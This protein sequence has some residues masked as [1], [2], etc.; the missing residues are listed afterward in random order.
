MLVG[1]VWLRLVWLRVCLVWL[2]VCYRERVNEERLCLVWLR[3]CLVWL[4][5]WTY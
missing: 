2:R 4:R 5:V 1:A 3:V